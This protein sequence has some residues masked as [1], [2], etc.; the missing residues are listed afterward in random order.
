MDKNHVLTLPIPHSWE[1]ELELWELF[2][3]AAGRAERTVE[4]RVR[5]VRQLA[6]GLGGS[7]WG[8]SSSMLIEWCGAQVWRPET[9]HAYY[10]SF[11]GFFSWLHRGGGGDPAAGLPRVKRPRTLPRPTPESVVRDVLTGADRRTGLIVALAG[12]AGLRAC[13]IARV[14]RD[15]LT[16]D[17][18]VGFSLRVRGKGGTERAV[19]LPDWLAQHVRE[20]GG[21]GWVFP[22]K[23]GGHLSPGRVSV[24]GCHALPDGWSLHSLRHR[25]ATRAYRA[26]RDLLAV[27]R[28]LGHSSV[29]TTQRYAEPPHDALRRASAAADI[30]FPERS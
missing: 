1:C 16:G 27:Q 20:A 2:L 25:F 29:E 8:V 15:D 5:H 4:T 18:V 11:R 9:R 7:P 6:R 21:A 23:Y 19:P 24:L 12:C 22:S 28:L 10:A 13:E 17:E 30:H 14:H 26:E 3:R